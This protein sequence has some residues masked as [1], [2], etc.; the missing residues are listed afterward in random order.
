MHDNKKRDLNCVEA[1]EDGTLT[2]HLEGPIGETLEIIIE[3]HEVDRV[4]I[5]GIDALKREASRR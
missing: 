1:K 5:G 4:M 2:L 3:A